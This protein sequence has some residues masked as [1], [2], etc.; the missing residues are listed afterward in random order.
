MRLPFFRI[1]YMVAVSSGVAALAGSAAAWLTSNHM[2][3]G[4]FAMAAFAVTVF[5]FITDEDFFS[6]GD[7]RI[8]A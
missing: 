1:T 4:G 2:W 5:K 8:R 7:D 6:L 3:Q